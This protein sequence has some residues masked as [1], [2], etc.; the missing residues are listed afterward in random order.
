MKIPHVR[1]GAG[2]LVLACTALTGCARPQQEVTLLDTRTGHPVEGAL[3]FSP[4]GLEV[5]RSDVHGRATLPPGAMDRGLTVHAKRYA[6]IELQP[7]SIPDTL[8]L[9]YDSVRANPVEAAMTFTRADTLKGTY[10]PYR[11]N[12][13]LLG[14]ALDVKVDVEGRSLTGRNT[15]RFRM[16]EDGDR[17]QIDLPQ[18]VTVD[19]LRFGAEDVPFT[20]DEG[21]VFVDFPET[22][23]KGE[24]HDLDFWFSGQ[25][26]TSGRFGGFALREDSLGNAWL[27]TTGT[28]W[29][30]NKDQYADEVD[31]MTISVTVPSDLVDVSNGRLMG[32]TDL[33]DG[34]TRYDWK[35]HYGIN[36]YSVSLNIGK[37]VHF[38]DTLGDLSLDYYALPYHLDAAKR[39]FAQAKPMIRCYQKYLGDYPFPKDGYKLVEVPYSG[40]EHQSAVTY[41]NLFENGYLGRDWTGVGIS[42]RFDFIIIHESGHEWFGNAITARDVSD[43]WIQE[44]WDTYLEDIYVE[45]MYGREDALA[46]VNGYKSKV[47]NREPII[48][49]PGVA[50]WPTQDQYFKGALFLHTLRSVVDDDEVWW[51]LIRDYYR[52]FE[53]RNIWNTDVITFFNRKLGRDLRPVFEQYLY[54]ASLPVLQASFRNDSVRYRWKADV[55][56]FDMPVKVRAGGSLE[57]LHPTTEWQSTP[58]NGVAPEDWRPATDLFYI[59]FEKE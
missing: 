12:N 37:Y 53:H 9:V 54:F 27:T 24:T 40:M 58:L 35:V 13:D 25:P 18:A 1:A 4:D 8:R 26:V 59:D 10:G 31:S 3:I 7:G 57:T 41:G 56:D 38:S 51:G 30:P 44:G 46:Y 49:P 47:R 39:Q 6:P 15:I 52:T 34:T 32:V 11:E 33:G 45:C 22:L 2:C 19:S 21:A 14:Y 48:G 50:H 20:R 17:I 5:H 23:R 16:L 42:D 29:W 55:A 43:V 28:G 36:N